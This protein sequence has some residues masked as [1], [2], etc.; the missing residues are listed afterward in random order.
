MQ[1]GLLT[2][3][4]CATLWGAVACGGGFKPSLYPDADSLMAAAVAW[5]EAGDCGK[6]RPA[7]TQ[8]VFDLPPRDARLA[9]VR[10]Y[11]ADCLSDGGN[12]IEAAREFRRVADEFPQHPRAPQ[13]LLRSGDMNAELWKRAELDPT[14]GETAMAI[15]RE[16]LARYADS[17]VA[18]QASQRITALNEKFAEKTYKAG[19]FY[20]RLNAF[21]SAILYF[22]DVVAN[23]P[24]SE[25]AAQALIKL[26]E[27]YRKIGYI[28]ERR[29]TCEHLRQFYP[30]APKLDDACPLS[31]SLL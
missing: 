31:S 6:A 28:E 5:Y 4:V 19:N 14:Y 12:R 25:F 15:Y 9:D 29:E 8:L 20:F 16:V 3:G 11:L 18:T 23:Y 30:D 24:R 13:A 2:L 26:V 27:A 7:L 1:R 22:R 10:F 17:P 21:D